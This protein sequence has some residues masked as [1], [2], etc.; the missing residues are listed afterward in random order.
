MNK[1]LLSAGLALAVALP[2]LAQHKPGEHASHGTAASASAEL[3]AGEIRKIDKVSRKI[4]LKHGEIKNL[5]MPAMTMVFEVKD[6]AWLGRFK[7]GDAV[8]FKAEKAANGNLVVTELV[9]A[10]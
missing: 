9:A 6:A 5:E 1:L 2:A 8:R 10:K 7:P 3:S 4:T